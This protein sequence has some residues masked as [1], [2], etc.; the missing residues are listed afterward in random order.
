MTFSY[1]IRIGG[2]GGLVLYSD[3]AGVV[4]RYGETR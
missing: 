4:S 2:F 1:N 3:T